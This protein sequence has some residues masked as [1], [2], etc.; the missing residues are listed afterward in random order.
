MRAVDQRVRGC[1]DIIEA[2]E[3]VEGWKGTR[4]EWMAGW[5]KHEIYVRAGRYTMPLCQQPGRVKVSR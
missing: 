4:G 1:F 5:L 2:S 3:L